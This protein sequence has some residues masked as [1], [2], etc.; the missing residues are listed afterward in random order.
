[1]TLENTKTRAE[2]QAA[3]IRVAAAV[4]NLSIK[5]LH[6]GILGTGYSVSYEKLRR[7]FSGERATEVDY[8]FLKAVA[9]ATGAPLE[10]IA[11]DDDVPYADLHMGVYLSSPTAAA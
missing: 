10:Y 8:S 7:T 11:G 4:R 1:M 2:V 5:E 9:V 3:R 6:R